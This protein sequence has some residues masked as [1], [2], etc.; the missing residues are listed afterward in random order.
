MRF[1]PRRGKSIEMRYF[2][3]IDR[4]RLPSDR[5]KPKNLASE[6]D[7]R[8]SIEYHA[9]T[10]AVVLLCFALSSRVE[11]KT[12]EFEAREGRHSTKSKRCKV[13]KLVIRTLVCSRDMITDDENGV[14]HLVHRQCLLHL[15]QTAM[16]IMAPKESKHYCSLN[17]RAWQCAP[18][19]PI[20]NLNA[21]VIISLF[22]SSTLIRSCPWHRYEPGKGR[23]VL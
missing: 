3:R 8:R 4:R 15:R 17:Y 20:G 16:I 7:S 1:P 10:I 9:S 22:S 11:Y 19:G 12:Q 6:S 23:Q 18:I 13:L 5:Y 14:L 2:C 21:P